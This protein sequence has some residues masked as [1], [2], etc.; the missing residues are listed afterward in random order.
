[1]EACIN[2]LN[3]AETLMAVNTVHCRHQT[4]VDSII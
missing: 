4:P 3:R 2:A 1:M